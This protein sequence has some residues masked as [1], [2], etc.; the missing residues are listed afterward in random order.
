VSDIRQ[1]ERLRKA[2]SAV[3]IHLM[4]HVVVAE[5]SFFSFAD[6]RVGRMG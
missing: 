3:E 4:D 2:L 5:D 1:T 6:E